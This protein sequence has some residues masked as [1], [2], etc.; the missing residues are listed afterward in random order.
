MEGLITGE[1]KNF[2]TSYSR[3]DQNGFCIYC[4]LIELQIVIMDQIQEKIDKGWGD[5][6]NGMYGVQGCHENFRLPG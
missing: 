6:Y 4:F 5:V 3:S 2:E 1:K